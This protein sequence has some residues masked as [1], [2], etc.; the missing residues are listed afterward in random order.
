MTEKDKSLAEVLN[1]EMGVDLQVKMEHIIAIASSRKEQHYKSEIKIFQKRVRELQKEVKDSEA[2]LLR[3]ARIRGKK[4]FEEATDDF[5]VA[6][7]NLGLATRVKVNDCFVNES[8]HG[9]V[10]LVIHVGTDDKTSWRGES[11]KRCVDLDEGDDLA[12]AYDAILNIKDDLLKAANSLSDNQRAL[13]DLPSLERQATASIAEAS[14]SST[15][16]GRELLESLESM[17][18]GYLLGEGEQEG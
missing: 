3:H 15:Q 4:Y 12:N 8:D 5:N 7:I 9:T 14:L 11:S 2:R 1:Q 17:N 16:S 10:Q 13:A 6:A 18:T